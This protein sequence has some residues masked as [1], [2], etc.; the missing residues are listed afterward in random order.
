MAK[1][2]EKEKKKFRWWWILIVILVVWV[3][4]SSWNS[5]SKEDYTFCIDDC[6]ASEQ[7]CVYW[8]IINDKAGNQF[9]PYDEYES[10]SLELE[11][12]VTD[13]DG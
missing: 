9:V 1:E 7:D 5:S 6:V 8:T 11:S 10:C 3:L 12:C 13:C 2:G 4:S